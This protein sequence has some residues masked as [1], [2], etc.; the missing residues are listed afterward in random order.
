MNILIITQYFAPAWGYG[1]P[2]KV[3]LTL[4]KS[5][6]YLGHDVTVITTDAL[7]N[8]RN[9]ELNEDMEGIKIHR[10]KTI[11]NLLAFRKK[12]F[13][14]P[15]IKNL[16]SVYLDRADVV[17]FSD[18]RAILNWQLYDEVRKRKKPYGIFAFGQIP[19]DKGF[20]KIIK[21]LFDIIWVRDFVSDANFLFAQTEHEKKMYKLFFN[22]GKGKL[23]LLPLPTDTSNLKV[24]KTEIKIFRQKWNLRNTDKLILFI[25]RLN[26][27]KGIDI[28]I[29]SSLPLLRKHKDLKLLIIGRDDGYLSELINIA[30]PELRNQLVFTGPLYEQDKAA[31]LSLATVFAITPRFFEETSTA[32]LEALSYGIPVVITEEADIPF[33]QRYGAGLVVKNKPE[34]ITIALEKTIK[35]TKIKRYRTANNAKQL[36]SDHYHEDQIAKQLIG[37]I[38][39]QL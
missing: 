12:L 17:L 23:S 5:L 9:P 24:T 22:S 7:D 8:D 32:S 14:T 25:G 26:F 33:L 31:V 11:S 19:Y 39:K 36:I 20:K 1:G 28:L 15:G 13:I 10:F 4:S 3:L 18:L 29:K 2:P 16:V 6:N 35:L 38:S 37:I 34:E 21:Y 30:P 27:L